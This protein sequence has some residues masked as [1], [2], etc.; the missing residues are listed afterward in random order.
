M[1]CLVRSPNL[2][3]TDSIFVKAGSEGDRVP[4][5]DHPRPTTMSPYY[6]ARVDSI[7]HTFPTYLCTWTFS[8]A[9]NTSLDHVRTNIPGAQML[10]T[11]RSQTDYWHTRS[12]W[13]YLG[14]D[15]L[16]PTHPSNRLRQ[17]K[18]REQDAPYTITV[19]TCNSS[20][21]GTCVV[22]QAS[23]SQGC[24]VRVKNSEQ[25]MAW[26]GPCCEHRIH[27]FLIEYNLSMMMFTSRLAFP[28]H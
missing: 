11:F 20:G 3:P 14:L 16:I 19:M 17:T 26:A 24:G 27:R 5:A 15:G 9:P 18:Q 28:R 6:D 2:A 22:M 7:F 21:W 8:T 12:T 1:S 13:V 10:S 25:N 4:S 23:W